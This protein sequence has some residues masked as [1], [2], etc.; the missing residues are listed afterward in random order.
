MDMSNHNH[1]RLMDARTQLR[2][3]VDAGE[4]AGRSGSRALWIIALCCLAAALRLARD[5][6]IPLGLAMLVAFMLS[7]A[8][9]ALRRFRIPRALSAAV[10]LL[11]LG[12]AIAGV[13][14]LIATPAQQWFHNAPQ[15]LSTIEHKVRPARSVV[16][17]LDYIARRAAALANPGGDPAAT[18]PLPS[19]TVSWSPIEVFAAT[20]WAAIGVVT[21]MAFAFLLLAAGPATLARVPWMLGVDLPT[22]Y[23]LQIIDAIR[24]DVGRY[25]GTL[26]LINLCFGVVVAG[27]LWLLGMP[28]PPLWG[29]LA[30]VLNFVPYLGPAVAVTIVTLVGLVT[31]SSIAHMLLV[32][33][34]YVALATL[35]GHVIEPIFLGRRL[36]LNPIIVLL[37]LWIGGWW[38]GVAGVVLALPVLLALMVTRRTLVARPET[39]ALAASSQPRRRA[40]FPGR[41]YAR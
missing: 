36:N 8:V 23:V 4:R 41:T 29:V 34:C 12:A 21:V 18:A 20:G 22:V 1:V 30:G 27:S 28:N 3:R 38:W 33:A 32:A 40:A 10:L 16:R 5:A 19:T 39:S 37:A 24:R 35:E 13:V 6:L 14:D 31:F 2:K 7:G 26:L 25:Y 11:L 9:E 17:R 15:V